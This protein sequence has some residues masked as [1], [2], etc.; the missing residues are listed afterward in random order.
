M[1]EKKIHDRTFKKASKV[2]YF[3]TFNGIQD[4]FNRFKRLGESFTVVEDY[5]E[6]DSNYLWKNYEVNRMMDF[7][8]MAVCEINGANALTNR[9]KN[10]MK[11]DIPIWDSGQVDKFFSKEDKELIYPHLQIIKDYINKTNQDI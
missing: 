9:M 4:S 3:E 7:L 5:E 8:A 11:L 2:T 1:E 10:Q 6:E